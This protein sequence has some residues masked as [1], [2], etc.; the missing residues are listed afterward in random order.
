MTG[1]FKYA[2]SVDVPESIGHALKDIERIKQN[3]NPTSIEKQQLTRIQQ[4]LRMAMKA[5]VELS[6]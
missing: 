3:N 5:S 1:Q 4:L 2:L 6:K